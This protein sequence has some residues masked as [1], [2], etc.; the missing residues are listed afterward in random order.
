VATLIKI[1]EILENYLSSDR[2]TQPEVV[3]NIVAIDLGAEHAYIAVLDAHGKWAIGNFTR[4]PWLA[5]LEVMIQAGT[6]TEVILVGIQP[7]TTS[8]ASGLSNP[9]RGILQTHEEPHENIYLLSS[10]DVIVS[11]I[12]T[13]ISIS[14]IG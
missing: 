3:L 9:V 13:A 4:N 11:Y 8:F 1:G 5:F 7:E 2:A 6:G 10:L 14:D 12:E